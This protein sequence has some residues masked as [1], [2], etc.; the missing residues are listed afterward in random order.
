V[1][2]LI[3][4]GVDNWRGGE[5]RTKIH[6]ASEKM[7]TEETMYKSSAALAGQSQTRKTKG[8]AELNWGLNGIMYKFTG[9]STHVE[10]DIELGERTS[11][12][13]HR[14]Q[15]F[16]SFLNRGL[17]LVDDRV[18]EGSSTPTKTRR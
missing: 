10:N 7:L 3:T 11:Q 15:V 13:F 4:S 6:L 17:Q 14:F 9:I 12:C 5:E 2:Y 1:F 16:T 8:E 18:G